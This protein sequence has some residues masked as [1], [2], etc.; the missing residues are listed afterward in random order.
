MRT[1]ILSG[2]EK[3]MCRFFKILYINGPQTLPPPLTREQERMV[4]AG[5]E[6]GESDAMNMLIVHNLR[7]VVYIAKKFENTNV[8]IDDLTSIGTMGLIKAVKSF[9]PSKNIKFATYASRCVENEILMYLRKRSNR[10]IDISMD[11]AL[12]TDSDGNELNLID[13]LYT[14]ENEISKNIEQESDRAVVWRSLRSL[15]EREREIMVMRFGL[16]GEEE[17]TQK[18]VADIIGISQSY[19]S[20]LEKKILKKLKK[21]IEKIG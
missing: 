19:I 7:L 21:E 16:D 20:R 9:I 10:N 4:F 5:L 18:E 15:S 2:I 17:K 14:D 11:E 12:S 3:I 1:V 6:K 13:V 8:S